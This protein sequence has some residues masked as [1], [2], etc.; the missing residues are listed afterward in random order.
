[1]ELIIRSDHMQEV[2]GVSAQ[3]PYTL[4]RAD[5]AHTRVPWHWHEELELSYVT[6]GSLRVSVSG[7]S[8]VF[9]QGEGFYINTNVLHTM[10]SADPQTPVKWDSHMF[11]SVFLGGT[12]RS[13]FETKYMDPVLKNRKV[14]LVE[15]RGETDNQRRLLELLPQISREQDAENHEFL[16]RN[17][18]SMI[19]LLLMQEI[20]ELE[21]NARFFKPINQERIQIMLSFI[22]QHYAEKLT[23][24]QIAASAMVSKRE[25]LRCFQACIQKTPF[26]YLIDYRIQMAERLLRASPLTVTQI[27]LETG[28]NNSAYFTKI[29]KE[30]RGMTPSQYRCGKS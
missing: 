4:N 17:T 3:Y 26:A 20:K 18:L 27:A 29:F 10:E 16:T 13:I 12:Y 6:A 30:L 1:M 2:E 11:H 23:L 25:C 8:Y 28:F 21:N 9:Q 22:H 5:S 24:D 19:W 7:R 15:F 14:E